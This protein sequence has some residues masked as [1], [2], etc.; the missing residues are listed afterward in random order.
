VSPS[1]PAGQLSK[2]ELEQKH[3]APL[4]HGGYSPSLI[5]AKAR[6]HRRRF[7]R[8]A[9]IKASD[10]DPIAAGYLDGWA[11]SLAKVDLFDLDEDR[12]GEL[13]EY[14]AAL[15]AARLWLAKLEARL[16]AVGLDPAR[17][18]DPVERL[19]AFLEENYGGRDGDGG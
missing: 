10:L 5:R 1:R 12:N 11:R 4:K 2:A 3:A 6:S 13:R 18:A 8:H 14:F 9:V 19:N 16:N 15:N 17:G 7:L